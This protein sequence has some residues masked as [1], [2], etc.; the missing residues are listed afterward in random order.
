MWGKRAFAAGLALA[1][2]FN[3]G[4]AIIDKETTNRGG[5]LDYVLDRHWMQADSKGMRALRSFAI[6]VSLARMASVAAKNDADR[7]LLAIR[8]GAL[9]KRF[10]PVYACA[11]D[12]NPLGVPGAEADPCFYYDS[13]MVDYTT[14]LFDLAMIALPI[15]DARK[16]VN[17]IQGAAVN[18]INVIDLLDAILSI[19]RD[20][21][22]YGQIIG[23]I[24]R[25]TVELEVQMWL[26]TPAIDDRPL[27]ARVS[28]A[29]V[30][31]L[32]EIYL[33]R[34]DDFPA[35][36]AAIAALKATGREPLAQ[37]R[38]F[39]ELGGLMKYICGL[40]TQDA[41][42]LSTCRAGLPTT[43]PPATSVLGAP[44]PV[45]IGA[46][47]VP[48]SAVSPRRPTPG[49]VTPPVIAPPI[50]PPPVVTGPP[51]VTPPPVASTA[52]DRIRVFWRKGGDSKTAA[53][54]WVHNNVNATM[55]MADFLRLPEQEANRQKMVSD[56]K[57]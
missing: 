21:L 2:L 49:V 29:D 34:N 8:I 54:T 24:Y 33:R 41:S 7:Q 1:M 36:L 17:I 38:F 39:A 45:T 43:V 20:A 23:A 37:R 5:Y 53:E 55:L 50:T 3:A 18:P 30:A 10:L 25:D 32:R 28:E 22:K 42:A 44:P 11:F 31:G 47:I 14:G 26:A 48:R 51:P 6:Q 57:L 13:A 19:A 35:W 16:L 27:P 9:T 46:V 15:D 12:T 4:C 56:L 52:A 40:V